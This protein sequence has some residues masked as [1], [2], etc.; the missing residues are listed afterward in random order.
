MTTEV[1]ERPVDKDTGKP[2]KM[3]HLFCRLCDPNTAL[4]G[5]HLTGEVVQGATVDC[6]VCMELMKTHNVD[7]HWKK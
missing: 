3:V 5:R 7:E 4:C 1:L 2:P 6:V